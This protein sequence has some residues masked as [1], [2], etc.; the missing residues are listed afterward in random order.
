MITVGR[1]TGVKK[2]I[3]NVRIRNKVTI[4]SA[5][6]KERVDTPF[7][8]QPN[9]IQWGDDESEVLLFGDGRNDFLKYK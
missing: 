1:T 6:S 8:S 9:Y 4:S 3:L 5:V 7:A 2:V